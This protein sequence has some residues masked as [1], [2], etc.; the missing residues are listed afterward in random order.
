MRIIKSDVIVIALFLIFGSFVSAAKA[1][2]RLGAGV[3][4][5][6]PAGDG[7]WE[8]INV[9]TLVTEQKVTQ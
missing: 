2:I 6:V 3:N 5:G 4:C 1:E 9:K 7:I 8:Q